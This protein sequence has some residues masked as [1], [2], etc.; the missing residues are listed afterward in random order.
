MTINSE[1][2]RFNVS[3]SLLPDYSP[4][5][6]QQTMSQSSSVL[7]GCLVVKTGNERNTIDEISIEVDELYQRK[8]AVLTP[9]LGI[10]PGGTIAEKSL[11]FGKDP[12]QSFEEC[13]TKGIEFVGAFEK[14]HIDLR[15]SGLRF[16]NPLVMT[17][18]LLSEKIEDYQAFYF[19]FRD[20]KMDDQFI[21]LIESIGK[22][23]ENQSGSLELEEEQRSKTFAA[24]FEKLISQMEEAGIC[25]NA[26]EKGFLFFLKERLTQNT[27]FSTGLI[28][29]FMNCKDK[30]KR[31][32]EEKIFEETVRNLTKNKS[33]NYY[34]HSQ[35]GEIKE[36]NR[37]Q[38]LSMI[39]QN[40]YWRKKMVALLIGRYE[41]K[42][43]EFDRFLEENNLIASLSSNSKGKFFVIRSRSPQEFGEKIGLSFGTIL[44]AYK[45]KFMHFCHTLDS[46]NFSEI[47]ISTLKNNF[48]TIEKA[49][50]QDEDLHVS[51]IRF[52]DELLQAKSEACE[53]IKADYESHIN[54]FFRF[55]RFVLYPSETA[56]TLL[57][58]SLYASDGD[59][60]SQ[61]SR[62]VG[63]KLGIVREST[64][65]LPIPSIKLPAVDIARLARKK[66]KIILT[67]QKEKRVEFLSD[68]SL[69][70]LRADKWI[71]PN[72]K[73]KNS[74]KTKKNKGQVNKTVNSSKS[75]FKSSSSFPVAPLKKVINACDLSVLLEFLHQKKPLEGQNPEI[76]ENLKYSAHHLN[77]IQ[78][79]LKNPIDAPK[80]QLLT[81]VSLIG[82]ASRTLELCMR[83]FYVDTQP[84][85]SHYLPS[86]FQSLESAGV[87]MPH[88]YKKMALGHSTSRYFY[89]K[90]LKQENIQRFSIDQTE[91]Q[92]AERLV[93]IAE[94]RSTDQ[95]ETS[96]Y[97]LEL[98]NE[99]VTEL[100][101]L[102]GEPCP[103]KIIEL[104][105]SLSERS[106][107]DKTGLSQLSKLIL[108]L[109]DQ[110]KQFPED[111][112][113]QILLKQSH[114]S[115]SMLENSLNKLNGA[116]NNSEEVSF[117]T[118]TSLGLL[119]NGLEQLLE[120]CEYWKNG[121]YIRVHAI[122]KLIE[123]L[124]IADPEGLA[125][126]L[127][128]ISPKVYYPHGVNPNNVGAFLLDRAIALESG[129]AVEH[130]RII[131]GI[132]GVVK[133]TCHFIEEQK[134]IPF[135]NGKYKE[136]LQDLTEESEASS[137]SSSSF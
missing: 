128:L 53:E 40:V 88:I 17:L 29:D 47:K 85:Q 102:L 10:Q 71:T 64:K 83:F 68:A 87:E 135:L 50:F 35:F 52:N 32:E 116:F 84:F 103:K 104:D 45:Y 56:F 131:E 106:F 100:Y 109:I 78:T 86:L 95:K 15:N 122:E 5:V 119:Q 30:A 73:P 67:P 94:K 20:K 51:E 97:L 134:I 107:Q 90:S 59:L 77:Y 23:E 93:A 22:V 43:R 33:P 124:Q 133:K 16:I 36:V 7:K 31:R 39:R 26:A 42:L 99:T 114:A 91:K 120:A 126:D 11:L 98:F 137:S 8:F 49:L 1:T 89:Y 18:M 6:L 9:P 3:I 63:T 112:P 111:H 121:G 118:A 92:V 65:N 24:S 113:S 75:T 129:D 21:D 27:L 96:E 25:K 37:I 58:T 110:N 46:I 72:R 108:D 19:P 61:A 4:D 44:D 82:V 28:A 34:S 70:K 74:K 115:F 76:L 55:L 57:F 136:R 130:A 81:A 105:E 48:N 80:E 62:H 12:R 101:R 60:I 41:S 132:E 2:F 117:W 14:S 123:N 13:I 54:G 69:S 79:S 127:H 125:D 38:A 66:M